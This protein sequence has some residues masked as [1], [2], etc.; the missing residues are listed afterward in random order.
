MK[1]LL[2]EPLVHF[3]LLGAAL[4]VVF[5]FAG[6]RTDG[7]PGKI[8]VTEGQ[9]ASLEFGFT[10]T[11]QR[12]PTP[13]ELEGLIQD[14]VRE[15]VYCREAMALGLD[16]DDTIIR[17]R[18]RQK[19]EFISDDLVAQIEP[20]DAELS[21]YLRAHPDSFRVE[22]RYTFSQIYLSPEKHGT[23]LA[24]DAERLLARLA[25]AGAEADASRLGD[26]FLLEHTFDAVPAGEVA[27]Q[28]GDKF[29]STL[30]ELAIGRWQG[31][32][33]SGYGVHLVFI[34][35]RTDGGVPELAMV[36]SAVHREWANGRRLE[37][38]ETFYQGLLKKYSVTIER[39]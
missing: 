37:A 19:M 39:P 17:R 12:P 7:A 35:A 32:V 33:E 11:W 15:E 1:R 10:R 26:P 24:R 20:T 36:R 21:A 31:P 5:G 18:L 30:G 34:G 25:R 2:N 13:E 3:L 4:F 9:T 22:P 29:A 6:K 38:N 8:V 16:K 23:D 28:F 27:K 14:R